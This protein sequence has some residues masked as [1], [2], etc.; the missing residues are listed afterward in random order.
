MSGSPKPSPTLRSKASRALLVP[1]DLLVRLV[2][3]VPKALP[4]I[5]GL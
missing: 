5:L 3:Q 4:E 2:L 1:L